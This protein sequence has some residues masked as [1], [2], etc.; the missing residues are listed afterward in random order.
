MDVLSIIGFLLGS[1]LMYATPLILVA[2]GALYSEK[3]GIINI[4][5]EGMMYF[6]AFAAAAIAYFN[7]NAW[8]ALLGAGLGG[9][10]FGLIHGFVCIKNYGNQ[11]VSGIAINFLAP[12]CA[13]YISMMLF[14]GATMTPAIPTESKIPKLFNMLFLNSGDRGLAQLLKLILNQYAIVYMAILVVAITWIIFYKT[15]FGLRIR[16]VGEHPKAAATV[17]INVQKIRYIGVCISGF[18]AGIGGAAYPLAIVSNFRQGLI[19]GQGYIALAAMIF[20]KWRPKETL[21]ACLIFGFTKSLQIFIGGPLVGWNISVDILSML[22]Y[23][24][25]LIVLVVFVKDAT[26]P[27]ALGKPYKLDSR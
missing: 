19:S 23:I 5:L 6:G 24:V 3:S 4:G 20:G 21:V 17:G 15:K 9:A 14:D 2:M 10:F 8:I 25:T 18:L 11:V 12:G 1:T 22:P 27:K 16:A 13:L 26:S 7:G